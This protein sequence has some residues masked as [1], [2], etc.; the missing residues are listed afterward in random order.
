MK[1]R[2]TIGCLLLAIGLFTACGQASKSTDTD[3][4]SV[5]S[6][7]NKA[8]NTEDLVGSY[9]YEASGDTVSL[10]LT[11]QGDKAMGHLTYAW[12]EKD[13][14]A[15]TIEGQLKDSLL[16]A[17]YTFDSEGQSSIRQVAFVLNGK[18]ATEGYGYMEEKD[19]KLIF[20]NIDSL[21][22]E[23]GMVLTKQ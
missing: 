13:R 21:R 4:A 23:T 6:E 20:K 10:H 8:I 14:N 16:I 18:T 5:N 12:K 3:S 9:A 15:G 1:N 19:G 22:F 11:I 7:S 2:K 17:D